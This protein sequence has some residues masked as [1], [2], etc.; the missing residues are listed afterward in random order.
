MKAEGERLGTVYNFMVDKRSGQ[1]AYAV[2]SFGSF[3]GMGGSYHPLP[4]RALTYDTDKGGY[5][6]DLDKDRLQGAPSYAESETPAWGDPAYGRR[7]DDYYG[8]AL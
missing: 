3:L 2:M 1:V 8:P 7:I 6:V 5:V 4:W